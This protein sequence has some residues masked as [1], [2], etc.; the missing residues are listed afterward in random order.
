MVDIS[1]GVVGDVVVVPEGGAPV[2]AVV[3]DGKDIRDEVIPRLSWE[4]VVEWPAII[5]WSLPAAMVVENEVA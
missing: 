4:D 3:C 2:G 5:N 1:R